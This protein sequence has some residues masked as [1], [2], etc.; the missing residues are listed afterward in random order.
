MVYGSYIANDFKEK[1]FVESMKLLQSIKTTKQINVG[2]IPVPNDVRQELYLSSPTFLALKKY[3]DEKDA[4]LTGWQQPSCTSYPETCGDYG[5]NWFF[6][7]LRDAV[8]LDGH[9]ESP[10]KATK[11]YSQLNAEIRALCQSGRLVCNKKITVLPNF[12][13]NQISDIFILMKLSLK[14]IM[15]LS[16]PELYNS[17]SIG[18]PEQLRATAKFLHLSHYYPESEENSLI[19][20]KRNNSFKIKEF[21]IWFYSKISLPI[22]LFGFVFFIYLVLTPKSQKIIS[23]FLGMVWLLVIFRI[24]LISIA[25]EATFALVN[26]QYLAFAGPVILLAS[27]LSILFFKEDI[28]LTN[29]SGNS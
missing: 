8:A 29:K 12:N 10:K 19:E 1:S 28:Y 7:A 17:R 11:F 21:L 2:I 22:A 18:S 24:I 16:P 14:K 5:G 9:Y 4:P 26:H 27:F 15:L 23:F 6:W 25:S 20:N 13:E 3:L